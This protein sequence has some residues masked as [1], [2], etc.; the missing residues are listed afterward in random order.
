V[1]ARTAATSFVVTID[2]G[3]TTNPMCLSYEIVN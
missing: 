3:P 1:T 2:V